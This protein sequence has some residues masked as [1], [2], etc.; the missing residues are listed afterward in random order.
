MKVS[1]MSHRSVRIISFM[2]LVVL[3][4]VVIKLK[5]K[6]KI[7]MEFKLICNF[8]ASSGDKF[9]FKIIQVKLLSCDNIK[10]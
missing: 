8:R 4:F 10:D 5:L 2:R 6:L 3:E 9:E 7:K 1:Y